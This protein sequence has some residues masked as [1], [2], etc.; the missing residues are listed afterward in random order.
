MVPGAIQDRSGG[1]SNLQPKLLSVNERAGR[2]PS[3]VIVDKLARALS[4]SLAELF[5]ELQREAGAAN[6][7]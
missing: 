1:L 7:R 2:T 4:L 6:G 5:A 3:I